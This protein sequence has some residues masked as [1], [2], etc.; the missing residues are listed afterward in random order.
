[1]RGFILFFVL[2]AAGFDVF[3]IATPAGDVDV[4][5]GRIIVDG[6]KIAVVPQYKGYKGR[7]LVLWSEMYVEL[8]GVNPGFLSVFILMSRLR[9]RF[10]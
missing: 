7:P 2:V 3:A 9:F 5:T 1:M 8:S 4:S 10:H 6:K